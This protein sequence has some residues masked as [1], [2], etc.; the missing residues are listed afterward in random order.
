MAVE[1]GALIKMTAKPTRICLVARS[2]FGAGGKAN[3]I[4]LSFRHGHSKHPSN[5]RQD[6]PQAHAHCCRTLVVASSAKTAGFGIPSSVPKWL[7][8]QESN[9]PELGLTDRRVRFARLRG[10]VDHRGNAARPDCLQ[11]SPAPLCAAHGAQSWF[12]ANLSVASTRRCHQISFLSAV[13]RIE[14]IEPPSSEWRDQVAIRAQPIDQIRMAANLWR[15]IFGGKRMELNLLPKGTAFTA[16]RR[17][18]PVLIGTSQKFPDLILRSRAQHG[19]S[20]DGC[21]A[22]TRCHPSRRAQ[23][24]APQDEVGNVRCFPSRRRHPWNRSWNQT[25]ANTL[26]VESAV[27]AKLAESRGLDP[28]TLRCLPASNGCRTPVRLT[29][30]NVKKNR[31][32]SNSWRAIWRP[33]EELNPD[34]PLTRRL[35]RRNASRA[36]RGAGSARPRG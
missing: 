4:G 30:P 27:N 22:R 14:E 8:T 25:T 29:F 28:H 15:Q 19:V 32:L 26:P 10:M 18:Q 31:A 3:G 23:E 35:H 24:R 12:R 7:P 16:Q 5:V 21:T 1:A 17:H 36:W 11:G 20:K 9:L 13:V 6:G 33:S 2:A 34:L